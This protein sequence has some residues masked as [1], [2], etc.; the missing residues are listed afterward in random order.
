MKV[1]LGLGTA[2]VE[3]PDPE[4]EP[5][6][7]PFV[8]CLKAVRHAQGDA[9]VGISPFVEVMEIRS[10]RPARLLGH[11]AL[12]RL[13]IGLRAR[14]LGF[15][16]EAHHVCLMR[17]DAE[18]VVKYLAMRPLD[19][20]GY[21]WGGVFKPTAE[22]DASF[23]ASEPPTHDEWNSASLKRPHSVFVNVGLKKI[24]NAARE[25]V[26]PSAPAPSDDLVGVPS[27]VNL[28]NKL[29]GFVPT[30]PAN[31]ATSG[32]RPRATRPSMRRSKPTADV[33][34]VVDLCWA[35]G[36]HDFAAG[37]TVKGTGSSVVTLQATVGVLVE[38]G[39]RDTDETVASVSGWSE[40]P[41]AAPSDETR[42][43]MV[44]TG[45]TRW[46]HV[47]CRED[48]AVDLRVNVESE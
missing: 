32:N 35:G 30:S 43:R 22:A 38:G 2:D 36:W 21:Q 4:D 24:E 23:A 41:D 3:V 25:F 15:G 5:V 13:P 33:G 6:I 31:A 39:G 29:S 37:V 48:L 12:V 8:E 19:V 1:R 34:E 42:V 27:V 14:D 9:E 10:Q 47:H 11:L 46:V 45:A 18:L 20:S 17:H 26:S 16:D 40:D 7:R 28:A 44:P